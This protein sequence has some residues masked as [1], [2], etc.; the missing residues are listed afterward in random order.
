MRQPAQDEFLAATMPCLDAVHNLAKRCVRSAVDAQDLVQETYMRAFEAWTHG[1]K[2]RRP[3]PWLMTICLNIVRSWARRPR[4]SRELLV[5]EPEPTAGGNV[6]REALATLE[7][8]RVNRALWELPEEQRVAVT[9]M[10]LT[11]LSTTEI[12]A[13][14]GSPKGTVLARVHRGRKRLARLLEEEVS[15]AET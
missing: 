4:A 7:Q 2:P 11:G 8:E 3:A 10:D 12:A 14:T 1:R 6:E 5:A 13:A 9:L 15:R